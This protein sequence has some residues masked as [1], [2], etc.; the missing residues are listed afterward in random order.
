MKERLPFF[1]EDDF[2]LLGVIREESGSLVET[3][4]Y[5]RGWIPLEEFTPDCQPEY[6]LGY[7]GRETL[8]RLLGIKPLA[9]VRVV[10]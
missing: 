6:I 5:F 2:D 3:R 8:V 10:E 7:K 4:Y 9:I 1:V